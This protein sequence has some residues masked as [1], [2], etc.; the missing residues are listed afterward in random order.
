[1]SFLPP[2]P[3]TSLRQLLMTSSIFSGPRGALLY[4]SKLQICS[5]ATYIATWMREQSFSAWVWTTAPLPKQQPPPFLFEGGDHGQTGC[6]KRRRAM[7]TMCGQQTGTR[8]L[9]ERQ[10]WGCSCPAWQPAASP[11]AGRP[12]QSRPTGAAGAVPRPLL[13]SGAPRAGGGRRCWAQGL[14]V[15]LAPR[16]ARC[17]PAGGAAASRPGGGAETAP[18]GGGWRDQQ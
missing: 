5:N 6:I 18:G 13:A 10:P 3:G 15:G 8:C 2:Q 1:M 12:G 14:S 11:G 16:C 4:R 9:P 17:S 7:C